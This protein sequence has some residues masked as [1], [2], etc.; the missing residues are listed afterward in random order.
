MRVVFLSLGSEAQKLSRQKWTRTPW[1]TIH[2]VNA[3]E[4][5]HVRLR[6]TQSVRYIMCGWSEGAFRRALKTATFAAWMYSLPTSS[7]GLSGGAMAVIQTKRC[8]S[9]GRGGNRAGW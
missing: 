2:L 4:R 6:L 3:S 9:G 1:L 5:P 7:D 8:A